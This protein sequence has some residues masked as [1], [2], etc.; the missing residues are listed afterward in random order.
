MSEPSASRLEAQAREAV[1][2]IVALGVENDT[3]GA[4]AIYGELAALAAAHPEEPSLRLWQSWA[5]FRLVS[6]HVEPPIAVE[7]RA[8]I[9]DLTALAATHPA[10]PALREMLA[11]ALAHHVHNRLQAN[12]VVGARAAQAEL[13]ALGAAHPEES[14]VQEELAWSLQAMRLVGI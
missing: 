10:E 3:A 14:K 11:R 9:D 1:D 4:R 7:A 6:G 13:S 8:V 2:R 12:D 5:A